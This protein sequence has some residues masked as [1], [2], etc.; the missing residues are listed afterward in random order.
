MCVLGDVHAQD[1]PV[2]WEYKNATCYKVRECLYLV[3]KSREGDNISYYNGTC[4][5][6]INLPDYSSS[7]TLETD[8]QKPIAI[9]ELFVDENTLVISSRGKVEVSYVIPIESSGFQTP[10]TIKDDDDMDR[11]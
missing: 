5:Q 1:I 7:D 3:I 11:Y 4:W 9:K 6:E 2:Q 10:Q 8:I